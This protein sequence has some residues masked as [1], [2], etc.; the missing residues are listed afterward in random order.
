[1]MEGTTGTE[2]SDERCHVFSI[3]G[4]KIVSFKE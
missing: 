2:Y 3:A 1:M 4:G